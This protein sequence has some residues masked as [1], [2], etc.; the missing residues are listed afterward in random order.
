MKQVTL[1]AVASAAVLLIESSPIGSTTSLEVKE[2]LR[3]LGYEAYQLNVSDT[4]KDVAK[5]LGLGS[6]LVTEGGF[7]FYV[8]SMP[9]EVEVEEVEEEVEDAVQVFVF[10]VV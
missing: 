1:E 7:T 3:Y 10:R 6:K 4:L 5:M 2:L 9:E 8:Y